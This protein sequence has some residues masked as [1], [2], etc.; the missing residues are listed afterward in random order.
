MTL[1]DSWIGYYNHHKG[2]PPT[3]P[4]AISIWFRPIVTEDDG[5]LNDQVCRFSPKMKISDAASDNYLFVLG[6]TVTVAESTTALSSTIQGV[7]DLVCLF[8]APVSRR[9]S[10]MIGQKQKQFTWSWCS[11]KCTST[12]DFLSRNK[13]YAEGNKRIKF[14]PRYLRNVTLPLWLITDWSHRI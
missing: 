9:G 8:F 12:A 10:N 13:K 11:R 2:E 14:W 3:L 6:S 1:Y 7:D 5:Q 4:T